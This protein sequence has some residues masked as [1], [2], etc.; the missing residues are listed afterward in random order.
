MTR[1]EQLVSVLRDGR[2]LFLAV[3]DRGAICAAYQDYLLD[4]LPRRRKEEGQ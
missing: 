4:R 2:V 1:L 3:R